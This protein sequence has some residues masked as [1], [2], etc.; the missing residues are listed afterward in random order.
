MLNI[1][2]Q[3]RTDLNPSKRIRSQIRLENICTIFIPALNKFKSLPYIF[4]IT[5]VIFKY[6]KNHKLNLH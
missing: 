2:T 6:E 4:Y 1:Q 5:Q 3:I